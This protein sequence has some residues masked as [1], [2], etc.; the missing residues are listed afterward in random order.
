MI[1]LDATDIAILTII[2]QDTSLAVADVARRVGL[3]VTPCWRRIQRLE[4]QGVIRR[5]VALLN[6]EKIGAGLSVFVAV[7]TNEHNA[8]W[9]KHF[10]EVVAAMPE[11]VEFYRM[12]GDV[13]YLL[14]VVVAD[15]RAYDTFYKTLISKVKL[16]DVSSSFAMEQIKYTTALP[17][18]EST[19]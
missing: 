5:R 7:R 10:A 3:S 6:G 9:L 17:L 16:T 11:V 14:R 4:E 12:S 15:M 1:T 2:Q 18:P 13:D 8:D 19:E